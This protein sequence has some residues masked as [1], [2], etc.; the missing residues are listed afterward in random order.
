MRTVP[1]VVA[2]SLLGAVLLAACGSDSKQ[3]IAPAQYLSR[4]DAIC[5]RYGDQIDALAQPGRRRTDAQAEDFI[6]RR[7]ALELKSLD[8]LRALPAPGTGA[9]RFAAL[10]DTMEQRYRDLGA[11]PAAEIE[12]LPAG[13][14]DDL[15]NEAKAL[16]FERCGQ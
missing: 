7:V 9:S 10:Y 5:K 14:L 11:K 8:E 1:V 15:A 4:A 3:A 6:A 16:G 12:R 13:Y 2:S